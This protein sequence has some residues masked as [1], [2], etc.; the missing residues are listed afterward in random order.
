MYL[1]SCLHLDARS[2]RLFINLLLSLKLCTRSF[3]N[4]QRLQDFDTGFRQNKVFQKL[5]I[6]CQAGSCQ[7]FDSCKDLIYLILFGSNVLVVRIYNFIHIVHVTIA[8]LYILFIKYLLIFMIFSEVFLEQ[9]EKLFPYI[10]FNISAER[11][12]IPYDVSGTVLPS[13]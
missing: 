9:F 3:S 5:G 7:D 1:F 10:R 8:N 13:F 11:R 2:N 12:I 4:K 6:F